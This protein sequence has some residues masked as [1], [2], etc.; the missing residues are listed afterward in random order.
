MQQLVFL[1][2]NL[3]RAVYQTG[4]KKTHTLNYSIQDNA[5][6]KNLYDVFIDVESKIIQFIPYIKDEYISEIEFHVFEELNNIL[7]DLEE[8]KDKIK[9]DKPMRFVDP[10]PNWYYDYKHPYD[11]LNPYKIT[12]D[13]KTTGGNE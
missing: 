10:Y 9:L 4:E 8:P 11:P 1:E 7:N 13:N 2:E 5:S 3:N 12:C 6:S